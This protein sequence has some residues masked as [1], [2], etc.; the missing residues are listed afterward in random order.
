MFGYQL[1][2]DYKMKL[3]GFWFRNNNKLS[4]ISFKSRKNKLFKKTNDTYVP[5]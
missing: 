4:I 5:K 2:S 1:K 3:L